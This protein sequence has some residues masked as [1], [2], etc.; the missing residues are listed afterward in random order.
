M[1]VANLKVM[2][3]IVNDMPHNLEGEGHHR[4]SAWGGHAGRL[5]WPTPVDTN[6]G[7]GRCLADNIHPDTSENIK[8][9]L[10]FGHE[11][12]ELAFIFTK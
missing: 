3:H 12:S 8:R 9:R 10:V 11:L 4:W 5:R 7:E 2:R 1:E 6:K